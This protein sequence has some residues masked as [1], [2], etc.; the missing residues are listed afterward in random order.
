V[1][2]VTE[3][4]PAS[5]GV[6]SIA[7]AVDLLALFDERHPR[8]Q[9]RQIVE[10]TGLPKTTVVRQL[11]TLTR[12]GLVSD[13]GDSTYGLGAGFLRWVRLAQRVWDVGPEVRAVMRDL[14]DRCGE[15]VNVYVRQ[16]EQRICIAQEEGAATVRSVIPVGVPLPLSVGA[17][18]MVL[19]AEAPP[20]LVEGLAGDA[21]EELRGQIAEV[22]AAGWAVSHGEREF[23]ASAVAAPLHGRDGRVL[24]ALTIS[25]PTSRFTDDRVAKHVGAAVAAAARISEIGLP[26]VELNL[27]GS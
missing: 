15:T 25:G 24:A 4:A 20:R 1:P 9:L 19:L 22:A 7:R 6:R 10:L 8:R 14:S 26:D 3:T 11:A 27:G 21:A 5:D 12:L 17:P 13:R 23:G 16:D 18:A 2:T